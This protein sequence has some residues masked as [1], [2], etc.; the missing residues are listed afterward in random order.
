MKSDRF[1][2]SVN[3]KRRVRI[4]VFVAAAVRFS[5]GVEQ[6]LRGSELGDHAVQT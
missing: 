1:R 4:D 2:E 6:L 5:R 3:R